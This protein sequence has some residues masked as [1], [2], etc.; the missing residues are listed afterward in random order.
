MRMKVSR[1]SLG[2]SRQ[3]AQFLQRIWCMRVS[4]MLFFLTAA[5]LTS[6][7]CKAPLDIVSVQGTVVGQVRS[8][9]GEAISQA[10]VSAIAGVDGSPWV[11]SSVTDENGAYMLRFRDL[12]RSDRRVPLRVRV[13]PPPHTGLA[14]RDTAGLTVLIAKGS[15]ET[16]RVDFLLT[17]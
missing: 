10:K 1:R 6:A 7:A 2:A 3:A 14:A 16:T 9:S 8:A 5:L 12:N 13:T 4:L 15:R 17:P 11:D